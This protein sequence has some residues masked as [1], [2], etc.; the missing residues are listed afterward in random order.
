MI[1]EFIDK[2][3]LH[4]KECALYYR[5]TYFF[6]RNTYIYT[7]SCERV[8]RWTLHLQW[9]ILNMI[10]DHSLPEIIN[11]EHTK[12]KKKINPFKISLSHRQ[13]M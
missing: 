2:K 11:I 6:L 1:K 13:N 5:Y 12:D 8:L 9:K 7:V 4:H 10:F 3:K